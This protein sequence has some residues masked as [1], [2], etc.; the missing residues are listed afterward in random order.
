L[1][2]YLRSLERHLGSSRVAAFFRTQDA[3]TQNEYSLL[4]GDVSLLVAKLTVSRL[5]QIAHRL[6]EHTEELANRAQA[7]K[8]E[9][10]RLASAR[11]I[12]TNLD[13][14]VSIVSRAAVLLL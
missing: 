14:L 13:R 1:L 4:R 12:L 9:I 3:D 2:D 10:G 7:L 11:K 5:E 6:D 8:V